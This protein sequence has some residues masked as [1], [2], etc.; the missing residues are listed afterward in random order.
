MTTETD[1]KGRIIRRGPYPE[2]TLPGMLVGYFLGALLTVAVGYAS[3]VL[4]YGTCGSI[5]AAILGFGILRGIF[6]RSSIVENNINQT[7]ASG[8]NNASTGFVFT[9]P[10]IFLLNQPEIN[11]WL[12]ILAAISGGILGI[13]FIIPLRKQM[14]DFNRLPFPDGIA[15]ATILK[16][17]G[18]GVRKAIL[19]TAGAVIS[20]IA[21]LL[22]HFTGFEN[23]ALGEA[24]GA[25][26]YMNIVYYISIM[27]IGVA[28]IAGKGGLFFV[29][30]G[31][32]CY[33]ILAPILS[34]MGVLPT[35]EALAAMDVDLL[36]YLRFSL[37]RPLGIGMLIG[38]A[39]IGIVLAVPLIRSAIGSMQSASKLKKAFSRDEMPI[40][41]L[42]FAIAA[43]CVVLF[44]VAWMSTT[45]MG[46]GRGIAIAVLGILWLWMAGVIISECVGYTN[47]SPMSGM[48][49]VAVTILILISSGLGDTAAIAASIV[50]GVAICIAMGIASDMMQD[51]KTGYL[52]GSSPFK[53]QTAQ[54]L[55]VWLGPI[56]ILFVIIVLN[57]AYGIGSDKLPAPQASA[58]AGMI[59]G[60]LGGNVP[61][62]K[63]IAGATLGGLLS[64]TGLSSLGVL[65][66]LGFYMPFNIVLTYTVGVV[67]RLVIDK[68]RGPHFSAEVGIPIAAGL[69][70]G[71]ALIGV[72]IALVAVVGAA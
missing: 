59:K 64:L 56:I 31:Y 41:V 20:A 9:F 14:I 50:V 29:V 8:V 18:A 17:P 46:V 55:S 30:G 43:G 16:S 71:E 35:P 45:Q 39:L 54:F 52:V 32:L 44:V 7:V 63:Y 24:I 25:P 57:E 68:V 53:Q 12:V 36:Q 4:G 28:Y 62:Q 19:M 40:K 3:L 6:R 48:T 33:W 27:T 49:L 47:W 10:A 66:G 38:G 26:A 69:I 11:P 51:L 23:F 21:A 58:L 1:A 65:V 34:N 37:F 61:V 22:T 70:I 42:Y 2:L 5:L 13:A 72:G 60:V 15:V 67:L